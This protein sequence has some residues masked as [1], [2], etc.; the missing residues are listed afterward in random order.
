MAW[1]CDKCKGNT[2]RKDEIIRRYINLDK[3]G[4]I[5]W[6]TKPVE[7]IERIICDECGIYSDRIEDIAYWEED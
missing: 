7:L 5:R 6:D 3:N 1:K 2:F 4:K